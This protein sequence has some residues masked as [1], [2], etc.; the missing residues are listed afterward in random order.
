MELKE[1]AQKSLAKHGEVFVKAVIEDVYAPSIAELEAKLKE[2]I[3]GDNYDVL[4]TLV[5]QSVAPALKAI[6]LAQIEKISVEV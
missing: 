6:L 5:V 3:P 1:V 4:A 2:L